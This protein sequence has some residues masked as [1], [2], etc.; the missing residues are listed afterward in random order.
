MIAACGRSEKGLYEFQATPGLKE[1]TR[2]GR[3]DRDRGSK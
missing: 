1:K 2:Q 3:C